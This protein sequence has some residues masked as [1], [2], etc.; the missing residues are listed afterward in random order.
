MKRLN[1]IIARALEKAAASE[2]KLAEE[3]GYHETSFVRYKMGIRNATPTA[4]RALARVLRRRGKLL[5]KL[6]DQLDRAARSQERE[7]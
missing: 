5:L 3:A 2:G 7:D 4:A 1:R 6:A